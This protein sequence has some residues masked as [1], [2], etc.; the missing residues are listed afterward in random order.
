LTLSRF[1][2]A[3][4]VNRSRS[5]TKE[6]SNSASTQPILKPETLKKIEKELNLL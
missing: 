1:I 3:R 5:T 4:G 2:E 6:L